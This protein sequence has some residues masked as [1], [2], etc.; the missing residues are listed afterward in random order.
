M[1]STADWIIG[2]QTLVPLAVVIAVLVVLVF[3]IRWLY[4]KAENRHY[5]I[6]AA[7]RRRAIRWD[8]N[9]DST[10]PDSNFK[11]DQAYYGR[12]DFGGNGGQGE[13]RTRGKFGQ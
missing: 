8:T 12:S 2:L 11:N 10:F 4:E 3:I 7:K 13:Y 1:M 5:R 9:S 6:Q